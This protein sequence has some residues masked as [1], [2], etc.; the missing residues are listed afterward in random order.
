MTKRLLIERTKK[1]FHVAKQHSWLEQILDLPT[2]IRYIIGI[3]CIVIGIIGIF[4][5]IPFGFVFILVGMIL[6]YGFAKTRNMTFRL[7]YW[8]RLHIHYGKLYTWWKH[9]K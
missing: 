7:I 2:P 1:V 4:T 8:L 3:L 6:F 9:R 5:P